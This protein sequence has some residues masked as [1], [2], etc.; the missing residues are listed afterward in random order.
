M[1]SPPGCSR[2]LAGGAPDQLGPSR[3]AAVPESLNLSRRINDVHGHVRGG[4]LLIKLD[5]YA[6]AEDHLQIA[7]A[8]L[9]E[10]VGMEDELT[11]SV[12]GHIVDLYTA[13]GKPDKAAQYQALLDS[14]DQGSSEE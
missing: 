10:A 11:R 6:D 8:E 14:A 5:R 3:Q 13:W 9:E 2:D 1:A 7:Y 4:D 12:L